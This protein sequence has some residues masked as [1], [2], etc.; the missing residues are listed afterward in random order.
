MRRDTEPVSPLRSGPT[1]ASLGSSNPSPDCATSTAQTG[2]FGPG[3]SPS[4]LRSRPGSPT[5]RAPSYP[6][7]GYR[8]C[9]T[10][11][12]LNAGS[13]GNSLGQEYSTEVQRK[14]AEWE[15]QIETLDAKELEIHQTQL[16]LIREQT[17]A[18][19][20]DFQ[21]LR[22]E[23]SEMKASVQRQ[24]ASSS[25]QGARWD[26]I[27]AKEKQDRDATQNSLNGRVG[28]LEREMQRLRDETRVLKQE[29]RGQDVSQ[30]LQ[31]HHSDLK[32]LKDA[33]ADLR[34][35]QSAKEQHHATLQQRV[36]YLEK[37]CGDSAD[38]HSGQLQQLEELRSGH[39]DA[40][41]HMERLRQEKESLHKRHTG[42]EERI[43][44]LERFINDTHDK[45]S[46]ELAEART[47]HGRVSSDA[48]ALKERHASVEERLKFL[49]QTLGDSAD[50]HSQHAQE[51]KQAKTQ[52]DALHGK[53][54]EEQSQRQAREKHH[55]SLEERVRYMEQELGASADKH[56]RELK[57]HKE[58]G[59]QK[60][61]S[62]EERMKYME[63]LIG[64]S[65]EEHA[66]A[67]EKHKKELD[68][69]RKSFAGHQKDLEDHKGQ[70]QTHQQH[71]QAA[72]ER[73]AT[74][75]QRL[76]FLEQALGDSAQHHMKQ[77][78]ATKADFEQKHQAHATLA[79]RMEY[80][81]KWFGGLPGFAPPALTLTPE[82]RLGSYERPD[83]ALSPSPPQTFSSPFGQFPSEPS[84]LR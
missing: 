8:E 27:L 29:L 12:S 2:L 21:A 36:E 54:G 40:K 65:A 37:L 78:Q 3:D 61:S 77:L 25:E 68:E 52:L 63:K 16:R 26:D 73:H 43:A 13:Q 9:Y 56:F 69:H 48:Q 22:K 60:H 70:V 1:L 76:E 66:K 30:L 58:S 11:L 38:K 67:L 81:E 83:S 28:G 59:E 34:R 7:G 10:S 18:F 80:L 51:L 45:H 24:Q 17:A 57:A 20:S 82:R 14:A 39:E 35:D 71:H 75:E 62:L 32:S 49:E 55:S 74:L 53:L 42:F 84:S 47:A 15:R 46:R 44:T 72:K 50:R 41:S 31:S 19:R 79:E 23:L 33:H 6:Y 64:D 4:H 5:L